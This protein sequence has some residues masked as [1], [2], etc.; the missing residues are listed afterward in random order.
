MSV[1]NK[2]LLTHL[3]TFIYHFSLINNKS[4]EIFPEAPSA[5]IF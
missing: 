4:Q 3:V 1:L 5:L 2:K